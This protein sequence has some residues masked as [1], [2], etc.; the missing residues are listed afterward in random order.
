MSQTSRV[1]CEEMGWDCD[2][3]TLDGKPFTGVGFENCPNGV[4]GFEAT[5]VN[6]FREGLVR[7]WYPNGNMET[8]FY[9]VRGQAVGTV[10]NWHSNGILKSLTRVE[11][12]MELECFEWN[13]AGELIEHCNRVGDEQFERQF[14]DAKLIHE[15]NRIREEMDEAKDPTGERQA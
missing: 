8:E 1:D 6:G 13:V 10:L 3:R 2:M 9:A 5:F 12:G 14:R 15:R 11:F 7:Y 4:L